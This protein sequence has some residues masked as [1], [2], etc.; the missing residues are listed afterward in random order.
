[1]LSTLTPL[2]SSVAVL[3]MAMPWLRGGRPGDLIGAIARE[4]ALVFSVSSIARGMNVTT[5]TR[6]DQVFHAPGRTVAIGVRFAT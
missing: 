5:A 6:L 3:D 1:M 2:R 4:P